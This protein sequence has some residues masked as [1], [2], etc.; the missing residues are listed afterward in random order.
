M[1]LQH[2]VSQHRCPDVLQIVMLPFAQSEN[3]YFVISSFGLVTLVTSKATDKVRTYV[4]EHIGHWGGGT[5]WELDGNTLRTTKSNTQ[6]FPK[7]NPSPLGAC[8]LTS[9]AAQMLLI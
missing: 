2:W 3:R 4:E 9:L 5:Q 6:P 1:F 8:C 7:R